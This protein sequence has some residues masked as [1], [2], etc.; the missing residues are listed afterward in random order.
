MPTYPSNRYSFVIQDNETLTFDKTITIQMWHSSTRWMSLVPVLLT[1]V[2][3]S[4]ISA[5]ADPSHGFTDIHTG[6]NIPHF[7]PDVPVL[8]PP[9]FDA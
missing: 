4:A 2:T 8:D 9:V 5:V 7:T 3:L 6:D 1:A